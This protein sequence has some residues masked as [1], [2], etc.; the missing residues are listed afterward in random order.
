MTSLA[1]MALATARLQ[2]VL[3]PKKRGGDGQTNK[4]PVL[5]HL[6][7]SGRGW[8]EASTVSQ[9]RS[10][11]VRD[12]VLATNQEFHVGLVVAGRPRHRVDLE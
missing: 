12:L 11:A 3:E 2:C 10:S 9:S 1:S 6:Q 8:K 5:S 4:L 7:I